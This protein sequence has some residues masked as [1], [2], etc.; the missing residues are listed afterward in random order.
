MKNVVRIM[1]VASLVLALSACKK[2]EQIRPTDPRPTNTSSNTNNGGV[3]TN[4]IN[5]RDYTDSRNLDNPQSLLSQR[6]IFFDYD[7]SVIRQQD[8]E[9]IA[10]HSAYV[11]AN[12]TARMTLESHADERGSREYNLALGE[13][14]GNSV[15]S[16]LRNSSQ[17]N[18]VSFGEE[19]P[20]CTVST[21][22]CW[23]DNRR[24]EIVYTAR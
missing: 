5:P 10:A 11:N 8:R 2:D 6:V 20:T 9:L 16:A 15:E 17:I 14:R 19:R 12:P 22:S 23:Q 18:V 21:D 7:S 13:R 4:V 1:L 24:V 3:D